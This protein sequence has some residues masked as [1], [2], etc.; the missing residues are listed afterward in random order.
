M[1][2]RFVK[3]LSFVALACSVAVGTAAVIP[4]EWH[5]NLDQGT[6]PASRGDTVVWTWTDES[7]H[8]VQSLGAPSFASSSTKTGMCVSRI[9]HSIITLMRHSRY[10]QWKSTLR[11]LHCVRRVL[12][13]LC[14]AWEQ[15]AGNDLSDRHCPVCGPDK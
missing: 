11:A 6:T 13:Q 10:R 1:P 9:Q 7:P 4:L 5:L 14:S 15:H 2:P 12:L 8:S 3:L